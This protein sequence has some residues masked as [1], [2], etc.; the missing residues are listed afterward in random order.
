MDRLTVASHL[1]A[2][3]GQLI[4]L[5]HKTKLKQFWPLFYFL[6]SLGQTHSGSMVT[7]IWGNGLRKKGWDPQKTRPL[8]WLGFQAR[9]AVPRVPV[10]GENL[11]PRFQAHTPHTAKPCNSQYSGNRKRPAP[12]H[13]I[14]SLPAV[15]GD[16]E[17][18]SSGEGQAQFLVGRGSLRNW[19]E[20][21]RV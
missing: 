17:S 19:G 2:N 11:R 6:C 10:A 1:S 4:N 8:A 13:Y 16:R 9:T 3:S 21:R 15:C 12:S 7:V 20:A 5:E 14:C 18:C